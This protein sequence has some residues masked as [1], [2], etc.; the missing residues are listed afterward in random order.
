[1]DAAQAFGNLEAFT[2]LYSVTFHMDNSID[3]EVCSNYFLLPV[4][5]L[6]GKHFCTAYNTSY[7]YTVQYVSIMYRFNEIVISQMTSSVEIVTIL[8]IICTYMDIL[9]GVMFN[10]FTRCVFLLF[11]LFNYPSVITWYLLLWPIVH[12]C[13]IICSKMYQNVTFLKSCHIC[14]AHFSLLVQ[15]LLCIK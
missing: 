3:M 12:C 15:K 7:V 13:I 1:M 5:L 14:R 10:W 4:N 11:E 6:I 9:A 8:L 2:M